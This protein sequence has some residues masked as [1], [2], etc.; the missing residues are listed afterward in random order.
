MLTDSTGFVTE[1]N[2]SFKADLNWRQGRFTPRV[3]IGLADML[4]WSNRYKVKAQG[5]NGSVALNSL[6]PISTPGNQILTIKRLNLN[7]LEFSDGL[8]AFRLE[9]EPAAAFIER[10]EWGW[11]GGHIYSHAL[12]I[13]RKQPRVDFKLFAENVDLN[14]IL[15]TAFSGK[16]TGQGKL[17]GMVPISISTSNLNDF[18][19][20]KGFF[21]SSTQEGWWKFSEDTSQSAAWQ[22]LEK[23]LGTQLEAIGRNT[24]KESLSKGLLDFEY[25]RFKIDFIDMQGSLTA[26][27]TTQGK[28]RNEKIPIEF[29]EIVFDIPRFEENLRKLIIIKSEIGLNLKKTSERVE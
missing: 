16:A 2:L 5:I 22:I 10:T 3:E 7:K 12:R 1:G 18:W 28:S 6:F 8:I 26:R 21:H 14:E 29:E 4:L 20:G 23:Q 9:K 11:M 25:S 15:F 13:D 24:N 27:I 17:Y 19:L